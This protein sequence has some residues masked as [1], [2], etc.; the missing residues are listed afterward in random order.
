[1]LLLLTCCVFFFGGGGIHFYVCV[2][3]VYFLK[4]IKYVSLFTP[5]IDYLIKADM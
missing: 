4:W 1:M 3:K 5:A 2:C